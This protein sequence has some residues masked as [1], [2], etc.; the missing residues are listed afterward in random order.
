MVKALLVLGIYHRKSGRLALLAFG[1][2][3]DLRRSAS[4]VPHMRDGATRTYEPVPTSMAN[5]NHM[6]V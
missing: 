1:A 5:A 4:S 3:V 6:I 2:T